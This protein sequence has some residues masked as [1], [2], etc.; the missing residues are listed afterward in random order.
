MAAQDARREAMEQARVE[1]VMAFMRFH[2]ATSAGQPYHDIASMAAGALRM[3]G[4]IQAPPGVVLPP[5]VEKLKGACKA[6]SDTYFNAM[7]SLIT[8]AG[9]GRV[10]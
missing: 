5:E 1:L 4:N 7:D 3:I 10:G 8:L 9:P 6:A 2:T